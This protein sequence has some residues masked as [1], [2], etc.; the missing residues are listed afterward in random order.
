MITNVHHYRNVLPGSRAELYREVCEVMLWRRQEAKDLQVPLTGEQSEVVLREVAHT[1]MRRR[2]RDLDRCEILAE[3]GPGLARVAPDLEPGGFLADVV[4]SGLL[5]ERE[6]EKYAFAH[7]TFQEYLAASHL[8]D[9]GLPD[10]LAEL[11]G[12]DWWRET[13]LLYAARA[14]ADPVVRVC[15]DVEH[16]PVP[17]LALASECAE[18]AREL[19][20]ELRDRLDEVLSGAL[21]EG[22]DSQRRRL[23]VGVLLVRHLGETVDLPSGGRLCIRPITAKLYAQFQAMATDGA[24]RGPDAPEDAD[25]SPEMLLGVRGTD[26]VA[27]VQWANGILDGQRSYRLPTRAELADR[28]PRHRL[29]RPDCAV[30]ARAD[31]DRPELWTPGGTAS[32]AV[33]NTATLPRYVEA[34]LRASDAP[35]PELLVVWSIECLRDLGLDLARAR[36]RDRARD[37]VLGLDRAHTLAR[38]LARALARDRALD[39]A[40]DRARDLA[41]DLAR[42]RDLAL[43]FALDRA[44]DR[45]RALARALSHARALAR[46]RALDLDHTSL[47]GTALSDALSRTL[48]SS[49][50]SQGFVTAFVLEFLPEVGI[51]EAAYRPSFDTLAETA[52][53]AGEALLQHLDPSEER[54]PHAWVSEV[55]H[56]LEELA[57]PVF[58]RRE[59]LTPET[60]T[61][62]RLAALFLAAE[63]D[64]ATRGSALG[65]DFREIA[66]GVTL[67]QQ[68]LNGEAPAAEM[69][70]LALD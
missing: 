15:L 61:S 27:F 43:D 56:R 58:T 13:F 28:A 4:V 53:A 41:L 50:D 8:K 22:P 21:D 39:H 23:A 55:A 48:A 62:I 70:M 19:A 3:I 46:D 66:A 59:R 32:G 24:H 26:A 12:G 33:L 42:A 57:V 31:G 18:Q 6:N 45:A 10:D 5:L 9:R 29:P 14:D 11:V 63:A 67:L 20:P 2:V 30:W 38:A 16:A 34:D 40:R 60:A 35:L 44:R 65:D 25:H 37:R 36:N 1:M 47:T 69:I 49:T 64:A 51:G 7:Q 54:S 17:A 68:R 52:P